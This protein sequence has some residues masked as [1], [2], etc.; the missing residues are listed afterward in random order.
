[1]FI[2]ICF[3]NGI[4]FLLHCRNKSESVNFVLLWF[5][6]GPAN[7]RKTNRPSVVRVF[8]RSIS[9]PYFYIES[10]VT[11]C[12]LFF[13]SGWFVVIQLYFLF[14]II[15]SKKTL[16]RLH[17][18]CTLKSDQCLLWP[19]NVTESFNKF[20]STPHY[21]NYMLNTKYNT[22][23]KEKTSGTCLYFLLNL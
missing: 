13:C 12:D 11:N 3:N 9:F 19:D 10:S 17:R 21:H 23:H 22:C 15:T 4:I 14:K 18:V 20:H 7:S 5:V 8:P 6:I 2:T 1:M 16:S